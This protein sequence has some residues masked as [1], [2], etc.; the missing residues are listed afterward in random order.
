MKISTQILFSGKAAFVAMV[1]A[2]DAKLGATD[3]HACGVCVEDNMAATYDHEV[4]QRALAQH[5]PGVF[6]E[7]QG[8]PLDVAALQRAAAQAAGVEVRS[9]RESTEPAALSLALDPAVQSSWDAVQEVANALGEQLQLTLL[10][11]LAA[12]PP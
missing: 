7:V 2:T 6:C 4:V 9:V 3:A 10:R 1:A 12:S 8:A 11:S 5:R